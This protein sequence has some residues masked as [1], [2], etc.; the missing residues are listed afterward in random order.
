[1]ILEVIFFF[2]QSYISALKRSNIKDMDFIINLLELAFLSTNLSYRLKGSPDKR[3]SCWR[4]E[5]LIYC[6]AAGVR[7]GGGDVFYLLGA[8]TASCWTR[9]VSYPV[10]C[11]YI[12][13]YSSSSFSFGLFGSVS[14][15][16]S[17]PA[18]AA[19]ILTCLCSSCF[20]HKV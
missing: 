1:M 8:G 3:R 5:E 17:G 20:P 6:D 12:C 4:A 18:A 16:F 10:W 11:K 13:I 2:C 7:I 15:G 19:F 9:S 14:A